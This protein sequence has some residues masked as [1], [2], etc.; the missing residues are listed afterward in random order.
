MAFK[1]GGNSIFTLTTKSFFKWSEDSSPGR[2]AL[3][4]WVTWSIQQRFPLAQSN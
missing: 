4:V 1:F 3:V 2:L